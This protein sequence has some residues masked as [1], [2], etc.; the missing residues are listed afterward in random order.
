MSTAREVDVLVAFLEDEFVKGDG[1]GGGAERWSADSGKEFAE[2]D[3]G[4]ALRI[5]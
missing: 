3:M 1:A 4:E 5:C 2:A